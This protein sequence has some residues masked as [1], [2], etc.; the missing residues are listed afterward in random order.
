MQLENNSINLTIPAEADFIDVIRLTLYGIA[1]KLGFSYE[2]IEDLKVAV[3]EACNN[4]V[5]HAYKGQQKGFI[6]IC[7]GIEQQGLR[8]KIKDQGQ[9]F[10]YQ[11]VLEDAQAPLFDKELNELTEGGLGLYLMQ[12][13]VDEVQVNTESGTEVVLLKHFNRSELTS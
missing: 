7:F 6:E 5:V 11:P 9:S 4:A 8:I 10:Q 1:N 12:A 13:L 2:D 3:S